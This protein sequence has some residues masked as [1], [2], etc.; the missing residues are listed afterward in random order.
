MASNYHPISVTTVHYKTLQDIISK[1]MLKHLKKY[2]ILSTLQHRLCSGHPCKRQLILTMLD[3]MQN[4]NSKHHTDIILH[5]SKV[6]NTVPHK[7][8]PFKFNKYVIKS[9]IN[10]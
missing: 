9:N 3:M 6:F 7:E 4:N 1:H 10:G 2:T 5:F 8:L